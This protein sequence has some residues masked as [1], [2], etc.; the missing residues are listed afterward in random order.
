MYTLLSKQFNYDSTINNQYIPCF[1][2]L[3][4][5]PERVTL[6]D[7]T[8]SLPSS[9]SQH[10]TVVATVAFAA[11]RTAETEMQQTAAAI[12][13]D[14]AAFFECTAAVVEV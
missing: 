12:A 2:Q 7:S 11:E 4:G 6:T 9:Q 14:A 10:E 8:H 1:V 13:A 5:Q 3:N